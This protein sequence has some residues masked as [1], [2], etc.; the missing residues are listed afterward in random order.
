[1]KHCKRRHI[2]VTP[3]C[4]HDL[5]QA[6]ARSIP[7]PALPPAWRHIGKAEDLRSSSGGFKRGNSPLLSFQSRQCASIALLIPRA[8]T[9]RSVRTCSWTE[10]NLMNPRDCCSSP[11]AAQKQARNLKNSSRPPF[12]IQQALFLQAHKTVISDNHMV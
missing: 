11:V 5:S 3:V 12:S 7:A 2:I 9:A 10:H 4:K 8:R 1:M 6:D